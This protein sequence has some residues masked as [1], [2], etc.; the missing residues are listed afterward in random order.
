[1]QADQKYEDIAGIKIYNGSNVS[2]INNILD[3]TNFGIYTQY[4]NKCLI[5]NNILISYGTEELQSGNGIHC[6]KCDSMLIIGNKI[7]GHRDGI[8]FE[9]VTNSM[10]WR[11]TLSE[12]YPLWIAF[13]VF[14]E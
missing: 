7:T 13:Y 10:I 1:M 5:K 8:Y 9:F 3:D 2:V 11:N 12:K 6:F 4:G 14:A